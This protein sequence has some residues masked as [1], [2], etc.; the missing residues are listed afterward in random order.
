MHVNVCESTVLIKY[1]CLLHKYTYLIYA[2]W[3]ILRSHILPL[4][5]CHAA[6]DPEVCMCEGVCGLVSLCVLGG[7]V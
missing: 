7:F 6:D 4:L 2:E 3:D 5:A 1:T